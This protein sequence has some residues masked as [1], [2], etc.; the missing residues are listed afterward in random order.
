MHMKAENSQQW[1]YNAHCR[2]KEFWILS[3]QRNPYTLDEVQVELNPFYQK[4]NSTTSTQSDKWFKTYTTLRYTLFNQ[5]AEQA[6]LFSLRFQKVH[7]DSDSSISWI[8]S[9]PPGKSTTSVFR[10]DSV[11]L[12]HYLLIIALFH[13]GDLTDINDALL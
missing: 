12:F 3:V 4:Q 9:A 13:G 6:H 2:E 8:S 5:N 10:I 11:P 7:S 1:N